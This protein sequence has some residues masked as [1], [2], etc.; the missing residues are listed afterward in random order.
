MCKGMCVVIE[1]SPPKMSYASSPALA[2]K[3]FKTQLACLKEQM[4]ALVILDST[5]CQWPG[6]TSSMDKLKELSDQVGTALLDLE[7][8]AQRAEAQKETA[9]RRYQQLHNQLDQQAAIC[10]ERKATLHNCEKDLAACEAQLNAT[11]ALLSAKEASDNSLQ[12]LAKE[13]EVKL[14]DHE[15]RQD[16]LEKLLEEA[17]ADRDRARGM[18]AMQSRQL[19]CTRLAFAFVLPG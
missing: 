5:A 11:A 7:C 18:S 15:V 12:T 19:V 14:K 8:V 9:Q 4:N 10:D 13:Q 3:S 6:V 17:K 1:H 2:I 16:R